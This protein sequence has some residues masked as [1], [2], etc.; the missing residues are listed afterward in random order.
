[1]KS[2]FTRSH[3]PQD[4]WPTET[5]LNLPEL[6]YEVVLRSMFGFL[7]FRPLKNH[8]HGDRDSQQEQFCKMP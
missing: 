2:G 5:E 3:V 1:M 8:D 6:L 4:C 7:G